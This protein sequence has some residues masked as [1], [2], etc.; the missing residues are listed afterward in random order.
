MKKILLII[1]LYIPIK[2]L[3]QENVG[4][5]QLYI[6]PDQCKI[7]LNDS[8]SLKSK[9]KTAL[10]AGTYK[11]NISAP[12]LMTVTEN[13]KIEKDSTLIFRKILTYNDT[14]VSYKKEM[15]EY[16]LKKG[17]IITSSAII[18]GLTLYL[19]YKYTIQAN[20]NQNKAYQTAMNYKNLYE[21]SYNSIDIENNKNNFYKY[22]DEYY[23]Y[24]KQKYISIPIAIIGSYMTYKSFKYSKTI[25]KPK[26]VEP[27]SFN[28]NM[29]NNQFYISYAF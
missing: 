5:L 27:L 25:K 26:Y 1:L 3:S 14:Y 18:A 9:S 24:K 10:T 11:I 21:N 4:Y 29:F 28:Y 12:K 20:N 8:I 13:L 6:Y 15:R 19:T 2:V 17:A 7:T 16:S 22:K 23:K